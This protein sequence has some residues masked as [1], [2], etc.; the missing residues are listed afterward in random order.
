[1]NPAAEATFNTIL[2]LKNV[3]PLLLNW[4]AKIYFVSLQ[5]K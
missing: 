2:S 5:S 4:T 3:S 1:M